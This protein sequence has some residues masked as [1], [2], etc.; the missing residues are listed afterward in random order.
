MKLLRNRSRLKTLVNF[1]KNR[2]DYWFNE[3]KKQ[4]QNHADELDRQSYVSRR[5]VDDQ[6]WQETL[7]LKAQK[8]LEPL[9]SEL[10][11]LKEKHINLL[12]SSIVMEQKIKELESKNI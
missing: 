5:I 10:T 12:A 3:L 1:Y 7:L 8:E 2:A 4:E 9:R 11:D 6:R